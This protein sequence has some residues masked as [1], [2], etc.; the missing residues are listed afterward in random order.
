[1]SNNKRRRTT[2]WP[3]ELASIGC[4]RFAR[5]SSNFEETVCF[6][7]DLVGLPLYETFGESYGSNGAIFGLPSWNLTLEIVEAVD[8]VAVDH[9]EQLC[10][11]FP[12]N[13]AQQAALARLRKAGIEPVEQH[14]YWEATGAVTFRDPD[15]REIVFAPFVYGVNEPADSSA[16]GIHEF[17]SS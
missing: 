11:Y 1:M 10:L 2:H 12:D 13:Q 9:H 8:E 14:P 6:Y 3:K 17:P 4:I 7:R 16:S 5:R 15:G